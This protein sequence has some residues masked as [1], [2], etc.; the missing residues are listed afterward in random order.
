MRTEKRRGRNKD[1]DKEKRIQIWQPPC[2]FLYIACTSK[3]KEKKRRRNMEERTGRIQ[4]QKTPAK[5]SVIRRRSKESLE[6]MKNE[7]D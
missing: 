1:N 5:I 2:K 7:E 6:E 3:Q 4:I